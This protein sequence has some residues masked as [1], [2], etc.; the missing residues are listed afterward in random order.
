MHKLFQMK[1]NTINAKII[2]KKKNSD[3]GP[4]MF[5]LQCYLMHSFHEHLNTSEAKYLYLYK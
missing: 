2:F 3:L 5:I 4:L 1:F